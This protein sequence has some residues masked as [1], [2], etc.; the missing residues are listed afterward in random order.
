MPLRQCRSSQLERICEV[1]DQLGDDMLL[2]R[3]DTAK[4][5]AWIAQ[6]AS[7]VGGHI[8]ISLVP[9][10]SLGVCRGLNLLVWFLLACPVH[11]FT[12]SGTYPEDVGQIRVCQARQWPRLRLRSWIRLVI[13]FQQAEASRRRGGLSR[14]DCGE[15]G[16][17]Y[18]RAFTLSD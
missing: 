8:Y 17:M 11:P 7:Y 15:G 12:E 16:A 1:N 3:I 10:P 13:I 5:L 4:A 6:V 9:P 14:G 2:Y 18:K